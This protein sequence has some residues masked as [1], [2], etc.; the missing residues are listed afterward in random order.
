MRGI[1]EHEYQRTCTV[2]TTSSSDSTSKMPSL[3]IMMN[4]WVGCSCMEVTS[5]VASTSLHSLI[6][7]SQ[8]QISMVK[9]R[10]M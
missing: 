6:A 3:P 4:W 2:V 1:Q 5:G 7:S 9:P 8:L 10:P